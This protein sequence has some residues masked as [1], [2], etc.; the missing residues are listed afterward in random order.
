MFQTTNHFKYNGSPKY[1]PTCRC[2]LGFHHH[3]APDMPR[4]LLIGTD[5]INPKM[6]R[7]PAEFFS[8]SSA[9]SPKEMLAFCR[10]RTKKCESLWQDPA[11]WMWLT[12]KKG[13]KKKTSS[14]IILKWFISD[15]KGVDGAVTTVVGIPCLNKR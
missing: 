6:C 1:F 7:R 9:W 11:A 14:Q 13:S 10:T 2:L 4:G 5:R 15:E 12:E 8:E 3:V